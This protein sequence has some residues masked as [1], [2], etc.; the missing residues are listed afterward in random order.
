MWSPSFLSSASASLL[1]LNPSRHVHH[2]HRYGCLATGTLHSFRSFSS[3]DSGVDPE[4]SAY[5]KDTVG[6]QPGLHKGIVKAMQSV[7]GKHMSVA[8]L[9][10]FGHTGIQALADSVEKEQKRSP[11]GKA[12]PFKMIH[13]TIP[14]HKS[15][16][17]LKW[18]QGDTLLDLAHGSKGEDLLLEYM[19]GTCMGQM[20][21]CSCHI[22][23][24]ET[25]F[26]ALEPPSSAEQD[27]LDIAYEPKATSRLGCQVQLQDNLLTADHTITVTIPA[28]VNNVWN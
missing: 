1:R 14:H 9:Q 24:D 6:I 2:L 7:Y 3:K 5:M 25:T 27:M 18:M 20:S 22:Y 13:F 10:A 4:I 23:L 12:R 21:C 16:F 17:D 8:N 11:G 19:E 15:E 28:D 26:S